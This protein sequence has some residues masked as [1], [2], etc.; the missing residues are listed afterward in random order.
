MD[1]QDQ[2]KGLRLSDKDI[3]AWEDSILKHSQALGTQMGEED[4]MGLLRSVCQEN[5][6]VVTAILHLLRGFLL[7]RGYRAS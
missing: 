7:V 1:P 2:S 4:L 5:P 6:Q 3:Q